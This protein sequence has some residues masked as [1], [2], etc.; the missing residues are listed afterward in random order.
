MAQTWLETHVLSEQD[1][2]MSSLLEVFLLM[3]HS[4]NI[5]I[6]TPALLF[7]KNTEDFSESK[8]LFSIILNRKMVEMLNVLVKISTRFV[9]RKINWKYERLMCY[10]Y[11]HRNC[12]IFY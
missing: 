4:L 10:D 3:R 9:I 7:S 12:Q 11:A 6:R 1:I 5:S 2:F 8:I